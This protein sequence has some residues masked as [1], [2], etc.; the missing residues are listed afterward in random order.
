MITSGIEGVNVCGAIEGDRMRDL[1]CQ[2]ATYAPQWGEDRGRSRLWDGSRR[3][4]FTLVHGCWTGLENLP[5]FAIF[6][7]LRRS[8]KVGSL[9]PHVDSAPGDRNYCVGSRAI[10]KNSWHVPVQNCH[11][12]AAVLFT[13]FERIFSMR[14]QRGKGGHGDEA[15]RDGQAR[16]KR[17]ALGSWA[18]RSFLR[19]PTTTA[20]GGTSLTGGEE[21]CFVPLILAA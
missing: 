2:A 1:R 14:E 8:S 11:N 10:E 12:D 16:R 3:R 15:R 4:P 17:T 7:S 5:L 13:M 20:C 6:R 19:E 21:C 9:V 18:A